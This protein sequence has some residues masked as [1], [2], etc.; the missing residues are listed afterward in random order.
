MFAREHAVLRHVGHDVFARE[1]EVQFAQ[2]LRIA[3]QKGF[4]GIVVLLLKT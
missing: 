3:L 1:Q 2:A 4:H